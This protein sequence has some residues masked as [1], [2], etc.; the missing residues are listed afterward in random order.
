MPKK[1]RKV[2]KRN[3]NNIKVSPEFL[4]DLR[5]KDMVNTITPEEL[6]ILKAHGIKTFS[7]S[8][9]GFDPK[10]HTPKWVNGIPKLLQ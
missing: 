9:T 10:K 1:P 2:R 7:D 6:K 8:S 4:E 3:P 5:F